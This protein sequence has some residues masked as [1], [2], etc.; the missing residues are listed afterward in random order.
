MPFTS[1][2]YGR[3]QFPRAIL[4]LVAALS[5]ACTSGVVKAPDRAG[6]VTAPPSGIRRNV[7]NNPVIW[8]AD[9]ESGDASQWFAPGYSGE[10]GGG[11]FDSG[12]AYSW[13]VL[14][15]AHGG[16][17][18]QALEITNPP[19]SGVR[20]FRWF[21]TRVYQ[22]LFYS[23]WYYFPANYSIPN[24]WNVQQWKSKTPNRN[25]AFFCLDVGN[26]PDGSMYFYLYNWQTRTSYEQSITNV[27][28]GQWVHLEAF[29]QSTADYS[30]RVTVWQD[31][32]Q[33]FD[34]ANAQT[35]Y[36]DGDTEWS[37]NN[38]SDGVWPT[39]AI[40]YIDDAAISSF[41]LAPIAADSVP[42]VWRR[43]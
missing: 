39:P 24:Y 13:P 5:T 32:I 22:S 16:S 30:G 15:F 9:Y 43:S 29:Y 7:Q 14:G 3:L 35:R 6:R 4:A 12:A 17:W 1:S 11:E 40:I 19:E 25:D 31:G 21:E 36:P 28:V 37:I 10:P 26:R 23:V 18:S 41:R 8:A 20:M 38:Y 2:V 34:V 27:P 33:L 42:P